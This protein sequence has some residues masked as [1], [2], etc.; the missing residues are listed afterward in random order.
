MRR[1]ER[2]EKNDHAILEEAKDYNVLGYYGMLD[3]RVIIQTNSH[4]S[5]R[6]RSRSEKSA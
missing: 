6:I 5:L 4:R 1:D 3:L 2:K